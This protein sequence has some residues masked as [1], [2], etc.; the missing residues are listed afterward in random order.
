M[1]RFDVA[2]LSLRLFALYVWLQTGLQFSN[3][4]H[5]LADVQ[6]GSLQGPRAV[7][8]WLLSILLL[9]GFGCALFLLA[10]GI[11][12]RIFPGGEPMSSASRPE[13]GT[14]ALKICGLVVIANFLAELR[15]VP[16]YLKYSAEVYGWDPGD[17][18]LV[19]I[20][21]TGVAGAALF[22]AAP[23]L[24]RRLFGEPSTP[25]EGKLLAHVQA[26]AF[27]VVGV[28]M[29]AISLPPIAQYAAERFDIGD[30]GP[31]RRIWAHASV[32]FL[33]LLLIL[34]GRGLSACWHWLR[35]AG[36]NARPEGRS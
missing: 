15:F 22:L 34:G 23:R 29:V 26:V 13:I 16:A 1:T 2:V 21:L 14:L 4:A 25:T 12:R 35:H 36:L 32:A 24:S 10:P 8:G 19:T 17:A 33:G 27:A 31:N 3:L 11:A 28:W 5:Q 30:L 6:D 9:V 7:M 18:R 20:G